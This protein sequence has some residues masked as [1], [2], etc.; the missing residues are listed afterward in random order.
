MNFKNWSQA[1]YNTN[2]T[3]TGHSAGSFG[4]LLLCPVHLFDC[5]Q[6]A[7]A[8]ISQQSAQVTSRLSQK[9]SSCRDH[10]DPQIA[11]VQREPSRGQHHP[12]IHPNELSRNNLVN[13]LLTTGHHPNRSI[14][15][16]PAGQL[17]VQLPWPQLGDTLSDEQEILNRVHA[18]HRATKSELEA[19]R[20]A[21]KPKSRISLQEAPSR[22]SALNKNSFFPTC[23]LAHM[24]SQGFL[25]KQLNHT[26]QMQLSKLCKR[27]SYI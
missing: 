12:S 26:L 16:H 8:H 10:D 14:G 17:R 7:A 19:E 9:I 6:H 11:S 13:L 4:A 1:D 3:C 21:S 24:G 27:L 20:R 22:T 25:A 18:P 5:L 23:D 2:R 15:H